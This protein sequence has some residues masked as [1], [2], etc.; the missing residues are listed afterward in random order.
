MGK[1]TYEI[2]TKGLCLFCFKDCLNEGIKD[3]PSPLS[4]KM[5]L[6]YLKINI[7]NL[8]NFPSSFLQ[9]MS[10]Q[11]VDIDAVITTCAEC[12]E[13][14]KKFCRLF[15][16]FEQI[17]LQLD[18]CVQ[19][20]YERMTDGSR[21]SDQVREYQTRMRTSDPTKLFEAYVA[22]SLRKQVLQN[23]SLKI[24][25]SNVQMGQ[26]SNKDDSGNFG[27]ICPHS[28]PSELQPRIHRIQ[29]SEAPVSTSSRLEI[30]STNTVA[31]RESRFPSIS[32][33]NGNDNT[34]EMQNDERVYVKVEAP[35][36]PDREDP[37]SSE[38]EPTPI[39]PGLSSLSSPTSQFLPNFEQGRNESI[40]INISKSS[41]AN[42]TCAECGKS[43]SSSNGLRGHRAVHTRNKVLF[44]KRTGI[45]NRRLKKCDVCGKTSIDLQRHMK[46]HLQPKSVLCSYC[47]KRLMSQHNYRLHFVAVHTMEAFSEHLPPGTTSTELENVIK[48]VYNSA[49]PVLSPD[50]KLGPNVECPYCS[51][52]S[53]K[54]SALRTHLLF[55]H[56]DKVLMY[57]QNFPNQMNIS[58][59]EYGV[60][61][62]GEATIDSQMISHDFETD[63]L[64]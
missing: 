60:V 17:Q 57:F 36:F 10:S 55:S 9:S 2:N 3:P 4:F 38:T 25:S 29:Y 12:L 54:N 27:N 50:G 23:C 34:Q 13:E 8:C 35:T 48:A 39:L 53:D 19:T 40:S 21:N 51:R 28:N 14:Q 5:L 44:G 30:V 6:R 41:T 49:K 11:E 20:L 58:A 1:Q 64:G 24:D 16:Q 31:Q 46:T 7:L 15:Q 37:L 62:G 59:Q 18:K 45:A 43:F 63:P 52:T 42:Y 61:E 22:E 32:E 26:P 33:Q 47:D 56:F